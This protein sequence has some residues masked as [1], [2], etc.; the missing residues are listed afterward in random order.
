RPSLRPPPPRV[1]L[2]EQ[3]GRVT[4][5]L[6]EQLRGAFAFLGECVLGVLAALRAP[7]TVPWRHV[8][9]LM[10]SAGADG[11]PILGLIMFLVGLIMAFQS[12]A[13]LKQFGADILVA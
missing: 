10:E 5:L 4:A 1:S 9:R 6:L 11:L 3:V 12:A 2:F 8:A 7:A 13:Q